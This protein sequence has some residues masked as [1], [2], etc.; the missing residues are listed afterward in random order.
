M[1]ILQITNKALFPP[2]G[3]TLA[4]SNFAYAY[5]KLNHN[6]TILSMVT[7]KHYLNNLTA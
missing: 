7:H 5:A 3:G 6:V 2:D 1:N 4:I